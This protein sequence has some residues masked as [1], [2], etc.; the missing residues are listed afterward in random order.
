MVTATFQ[1]DEYLITSDLTASRFSSR[2]F[3]I[4]DELKVKC[5]VQCKPKKCKH[6]RICKKCKTPKHRGAFKS[7]EMLNVILIFL[8]K[9]NLILEKMW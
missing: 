4:N 3:F 8:R 7:E 6:D 9:K 5:W 2:Q 1:F